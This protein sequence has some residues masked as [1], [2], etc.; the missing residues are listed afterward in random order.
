MQTL[1]Y[2]PSLDIIHIEPINKKII[3]L[4][5]AAELTFLL[6][7]KNTGPFRLCRLH[8]RLPLRT[9]GFYLLLKPL[10]K[11][12]DYSISIKYDPK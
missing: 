10:Y 12:L 9:S 8:C 1:F 4:R 11:K 7:H 3:N 5:N 2:K 6:T